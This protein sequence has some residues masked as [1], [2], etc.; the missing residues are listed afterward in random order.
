[1][2][3]YTDRFGFAKPEP[4]DPESVTPINNNMVKIDALMNM[5]VGLPTN[6][7]NAPNGMLFYDKTLDL[8]AL[9]AHGSIIYIAPRIKPQGKK[10][11][12]L[13]N[14]NGGS[15][16]NAEAVTTLQATFT[17]EAGR[18]YVVEV[19]FPVRWISGGTSPGL[20]FFRSK[21][22]WAQAA[23]IN[24]SSTLL[25]QSNCTVF[26]PVGIYKTFARKFEFFPNV[27]GQVTVGLCLEATSTI[28][29]GQLYAGGAGRNAYIIVRDYGT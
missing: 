10:A 6:L 18:K 13:V 2:T 25:F 7:A 29:A 17:A 9:K 5:I 1:M 20:M 16:T 28:Q 11:Y 22:R 23:S 15:F 21:Y 12:T 8:I 27:D 3:T 14:A 24:A 26:G 4:T 19:V